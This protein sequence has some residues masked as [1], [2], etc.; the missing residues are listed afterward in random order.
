[1]GEWRYSSTI[2]DLGGGLSKRLGSTPTRFAPG[3]RWT[4]AGWAPEPVWTLWS[5]GK[6]VVPL[7][8]IEPRPVVH[9]CTDC[10]M[11]AQEALLRKNF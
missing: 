2:L 7:P 9:P 1:M 3:T 4:E 8:E 6:S 5:G 11:S 10:V